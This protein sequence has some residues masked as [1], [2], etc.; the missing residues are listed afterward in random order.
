M[1]PQRQTIELASPP[2]RDVVPAV[3]KAS[4]LSRSEEPGK[5]TPVQNR[6]SLEQTPDADK[7]GVF[8]FP[9]IVVV[10]DDVS[11]G[12]HAVRVLANVFR[13][14]E[15][16][17]QLLPR[18][19]RFDFLE[20]A[21]CFARALADATDADIIVI[22]TNSN[23]GLTISVEDWIKSCLQRKLESSAA[24]VALLGPDPDMDEQDSPRLQFLEGA[25]RKAGLDFFAPKSQC[26]HQ[27]LDDDQ[28]A[29]K[30]QKANTPKPKGHICYKGIRP[31]NVLTICRITAIIWLNAALAQA[32]TAPTDSAPHAVPTLKPSDTN[33]WQNGVG[34][35]FKHGTQSISFNAGAGYGLKILG[36][37]ERHD[38]ALQSISYGYMLGPVKGEDHWYRG[39]WEFRGELFSGA[40]FSPTSDWLVG[41]TPHLRYNFATGTRW[42]PF[43]DAGAGVSA[44]DIGPPDLS[45]YFEFNLQAA[46]GIRW[47]IRDNVALS[48]EARYLHMSCAGISSPNLGLN[49]V[50][51]MVGISWFF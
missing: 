31:G 1:K 26:R 12:Q 29:S 40:Q 36:S 23:H 9:K 16:R 33:I 39:N 22:A 49:N 27:F 4:I 20:D 28:I 2:S 21:D 44:T 48:I 45:H 5:I 42:I 13:E 51:G 15:D 10:Y 37:K 8:P 35:G 7:A 6:L 41:L 24:V 17:L 18:F 14:P 19:W 38:L 30:K 34:E 11:A 3:V 25:A 43:I 32:Q 47:F 50:N 46:A